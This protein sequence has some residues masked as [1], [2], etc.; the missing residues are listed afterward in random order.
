MCGLGLE[1]RSA[2]WTGVSLASLPAP[3]K[4]RMSLSA[5]PDGEGR[6]GRQCYPLAP[7]FRGYGQGTWPLLG[8]GM[9]SGA[10]GLLVG[11]VTL[12]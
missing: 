3:V 8:A 9:G 1:L 4:P 2:G 10:Q 12:S 11:L 7:T 6:P 5:R